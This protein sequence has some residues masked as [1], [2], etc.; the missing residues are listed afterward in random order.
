MNWLLILGGGSDIGKAISHKFAKEGF[1][2][3]LAG[4]R[5]EE[6]EKDAKDIE[7]RYGVKACALEFDAVSYKSHKGFYENI[8][9]KP[10]GVVCVFG[11]LGDKK[12]ADVDFDE[13]EKII[14]VNYTGA[15]SILNIIANDFEEKKKG[16]IIGI[17]SVAGDRGRQSN[18]LYGSAKAGFTAYLAG[19]R[20]RLFK[21]NVS[22]LTVKPGFVR[23]KMVDN[24]KLPPLITAEP[25]EV[26]KDIY[27]AWKKKKDCIYTKWFWKYIMLIIKYIPEGMFKRMSL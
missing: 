8:K 21:A 3:Y 13:A 23:T 15:A 9:E 12:K 6:L 7:I 11:Y 24:A 18:C 14:A 5:K 17:S 2:I 27:N 10:A 20:N 22:V 25:E 16:F 19:L 1:S 26:A 4:R